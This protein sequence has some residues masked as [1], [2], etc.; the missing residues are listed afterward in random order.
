MPVIKTALQR[1]GLPLSHSAGSTST[2][3]ATIVLNASAPTLQS[4]GFHS[5]ATVGS[6]LLEGKYDKCV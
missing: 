3:R 4:L 6:A 2:H 1:R 5:L